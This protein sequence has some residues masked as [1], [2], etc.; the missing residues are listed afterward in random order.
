[1]QCA[2]M[3]VRAKSRMHLRE[4]ILPGEGR[5]GSHQGHDM[6]DKVRVG[7]EGGYAPGCQRH[8]LGGS[9]SLAA[10]TPLD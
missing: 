4:G 5:E 8:G 3:Q 1:M 10:P 9:G 7:L 2:L 6:D